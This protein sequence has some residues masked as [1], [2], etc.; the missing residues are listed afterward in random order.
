MHLGL[1]HLAHQV[2]FGSVSDAL[3]EPKSRARA[4]TAFGWIAGGCL[5]LL[6]NY[7]IYL[8]VGEAYPKEPTTFAFFAGGSMLGMWISDKTGPAGFRKLGIAAGVLLSAV[9][10]LLVLVLISNR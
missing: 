2:T 10:A 9:L 3:S 1:T 8:W 4:R 5:G 6:L 7:P